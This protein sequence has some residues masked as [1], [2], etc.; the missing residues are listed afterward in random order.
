MWVGSVRRA[1]VW[2]LL[3]G[4]SVGTA[5]M[6]MAPPALA[7]P[8]IS[9]LAVD[10]AR[11]AL[12]G[13]FS[14]AGELA[15][16]SGDPAAVKLVELLYLREHWKDAGYARIIAFL[17]AAP[18]WPL[19][20]TLMRRA[21]QTL[22]T[23]QEPVGVIQAY[24]ANRQPVSNEGRL[25]MARAFLANGNAAMA[26]NL[27]QAV[28]NDADV[29]ADEEKMIVAEFGSLLNGDDYKR[30]MWRMV[31]A[32]AGNGAVRSSKRLGSDY[33]AAAKV[34][35]QLLR[36]VNGADGQY[37]RLPG[38]IREQLGMKYA[39]VNFYRKREQYAKARAILLS[40]PGNLA[41]M[42][43]GDAWWVE[44]RIVAR[45]S[46]GVMHRESEKAAYAIAR[47]HG[48]ASGPNAV[49]GEF[50]AGW[51]AL[52]ALHDPDTALGH[53]RKLADIAPTRTEKSRAAYWMG[54]AFAMGG[55]KG[56]ARRA[57]EQAAQYSTLYY[58]QLARE[59]T[60]LGK[61]PEDMAGG[62]PSANAVA[63]VDQDEVAR[64]LQIMAQTGDKST[65]NMFIWSLANRFNTVDEMNAAAALAKNVGGTTMALRLAKAASQRNL[66]IDYWAYPTKALPAW[67][68][69]GGPIERA[70]V[71]GLSRQ[72]S[73]FD[74]TAGSKVGAQGLMQ[75][76]PGTARLIARQYGLPYSAG[77]LK[78]DPAYNVKLGA[79]HLADLVNEFGGSYV[80]TLVAYNAGPRR[81]RE[82]VAEYGDPRGGQVDPIDWVESIPFQETRQYV[83]KVLQNTHVYR[84]RLAPDTVRPMTADLMRGAPA[85]IAIA[86]NDD[87]GTSQCAGLSISSLIKS[88][89]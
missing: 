73:E 15:N 56:D 77:K 54:R 59:K 5:D 67:P 74:P 57:Y 71:F 39:L 9:G 40:V 89:D 52:Q 37:Q 58:G 55:N 4:A 87:P 53:F 63:R 88:C 86:A 11:Q 41:A 47:A 28:W 25:A 35:Q 76:M 21:E 80:L 51:I 49:E 23:N 22:Y 20:E 30:R 1:V 48:F 17:N 33:Q 50:L 61:V 2:A 19:A 83:Q 18:K 8:Q 45:H 66:D 82:W 7:Q 62:Q 84:S 34:A 6:L 16:R 43:D 10:A 3:L 29:P 42:G 27:V 78:G 31:Y 12:R 65:Y 14:D 38:A 24:F 79:A 13:N 69:L 32:Q 60:G 46:V 75:I 36:G 44:R 70:L 26:R 81:A 68:Q 85:A 72:E 64:A